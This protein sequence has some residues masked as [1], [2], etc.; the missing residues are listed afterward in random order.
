MKQDGYN[1]SKKPDLKRSQAPE[2]QS[3]C[4]KG[5]SDEE[6]HVLTDCYQQNCTEHE[7]KGKS[8]IKGCQ[9]LGRYSIMNCTCSH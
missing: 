6:H 7:E 4:S 8:S 3:G 9:R 1:R 5:Q 2:N